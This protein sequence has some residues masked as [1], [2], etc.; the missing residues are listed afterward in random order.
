MGGKVLVLNAGSSSLKFKVFGLE[1]FAAGMGG[2]FDRIGDT[3]AST[4]IAK[5]P[6]PGQT[7]G[8]A[9]GVPPTTKWNLKIPVK[10]HVGAMENIMA[11][12]KVSAWAV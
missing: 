3:A 11:F 2:M 6:T 8:P 9:G 1:P 7:P 12:L 4:L 5:G 10:D